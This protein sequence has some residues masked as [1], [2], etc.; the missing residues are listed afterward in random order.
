MRH[1]GHRFIDQLYTQTEGAVTIAELL[2]VLVISSIVLIVALNGQAFVD[3]L[4]QRFFRSVTLETEARLLLQSLESD[5]SSSES[6]AEQDGSWVLVRLHNEN[7]RYR[8]ADS[9]LWRN[10][11]KLVASGVVVSEFRLQADTLYVSQGRTRNG[12]ETLVAN[13]PPPATVRIRTEALLLYRGR[14]MDV[15]ASETLKPR[16]PYH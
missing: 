5:L 12:P 10:G 7:V 6:V 15:T 1:F 8:F 4:S 2:V 14:S 11:E 13:S 9:A 3:R 16:A